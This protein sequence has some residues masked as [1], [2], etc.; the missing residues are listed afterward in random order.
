MLIYSIVATEY[1]LG[2]EEMAKRKKL[3]GSIK[4]RSQFQNPV[5]K[6]WTKRGK[7]GKI[8]SVKS[9]SKPYK[10]VRREK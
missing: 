10:N 3:V 2:V 1:F 4:G 6:K 7:D 8:M 9:D 5:T